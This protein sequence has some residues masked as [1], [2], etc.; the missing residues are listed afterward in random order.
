MSEQPKKNEAAG[1]Q[2]VLSGLVMCDLISGKSLIET[3]ERQ[4]Q[5]ADE[6]MTLEQHIDLAIDMVMRYAAVA[7][8]KACADAVQNCE[9]I[10]PRV[11]RI[12]LEEAIGAC[13]DADMYRGT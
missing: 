1:G 13:F 11:R 8:R 7:Q 12:R 6:Y 5:D 3:F 10:A 4:T 2:S 9:L